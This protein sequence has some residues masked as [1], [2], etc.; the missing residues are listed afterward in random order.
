MTS[1]SRKSQ[2][3]PKGQHYR[4]YFRPIRYQTPDGYRF[5]YLSKWGDRMRWAYQSKDGTIK[6]RGYYK[7]VSSTATSKEYEGVTTYSNRPPDPSLTKTSDS[8]SNEPA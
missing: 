3:K 2:K 7:C 4:G 6:E 1:I 5:T 8:V